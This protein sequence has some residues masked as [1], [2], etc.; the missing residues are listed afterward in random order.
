MHV[1]YS[2][3]MQS[4]TMLCHVFFFF[5]RSSILDPEEQNVLSS[6]KSQYIEKSPVFTVS[7]LTIWEIKYKAHSIAR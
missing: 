4:I 6:S 3:G 2:L 7:D 5:C 1:M